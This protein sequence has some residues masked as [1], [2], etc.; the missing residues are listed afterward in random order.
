[1]QIQG[2][3]MFLLEKQFSYPQASRRVF[4][5]SLQYG[6]LHLLLFS[7]YSFVRQIGV[8]SGMEIEIYKV[9]ST[10]LFFSFIVIMNLV[11][12]NLGLNA[13]FVV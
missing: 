11:L 7:F 8:H 9:Q 4:F 1:M 10:K 2:E 6:L 13:K 5:L 12:M 3:H